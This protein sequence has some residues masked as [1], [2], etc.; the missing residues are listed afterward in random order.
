MV[1]NKDRMEK[2]VAEIQDM[3]SEHLIIHGYMSILQK[4]RTL[5]RKYLF[6]FCTDRF[7]TDIEYFPLFFKCNTMQLMLK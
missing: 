5:E 6:F 3:V 4:S 1:N 2:S 7:I